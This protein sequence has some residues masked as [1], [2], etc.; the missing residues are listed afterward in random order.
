ATGQVRR[1]IAARGLP[2]GT[3]EEGD[4]GRWFWQ[5][6]DGAR[7]EKLEDIERLFLL[8]PSQRFVLIGDDSQ[9]DPE[10][11]ATLLE[12]HPGARLEP[13]PDPDWEQTWIEARDHFVQTWRAHGHAAADALLA[14]FPR[15]RTFPKKRDE[16]DVLVS[17]PLVDADDLTVLDPTSKLLPTPC[18]RTFSGRMVSQRFNGPLPTSPVWDSADR[19]CDA[20]YGRSLLF[21]HSCIEQIVHVLQ[22]RKSRTGTL[23]YGDLLV[24]LDAA[25]SGE[26]AEALRAQVRQCYQVA[27]IDE[28]Q[29][30]DPVQ[31]RIF[32]QLFD[33]ADLRLFL[34]GDP[35][36]AI[37][38]FR[39]ADVQTYL[40]AREKATAG[41]FTLERNYRSDRRLVM[42]LN[43]LF[44][45][46]GRL[47]DTVFGDPPGD[48]QGIRYVP[49]DTPPEHH[50]DRLTGGEP[51]L[52]IV[53]FPGSLNDSSK[54]AGRSTMPLGKTWALQNL[55]RHLAGEMTALLRSGATIRRAP[56]DEPRAVRP[57]DL[58]VIVRS[59]DQARRVQS[60]LQQAG[61]PAVI[62]SGGD[63]LDTP[64]AATLQGLL[65]ALAHPTDASLVRTALITPVFGITGSGLDT[66]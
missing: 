45:Q 16:V 25:L 14:A 35:K 34:I 38:A 36:Q 1:R 64:E 5:G 60:A 2:A 20:A 15:N 41:T 3:L 63:V 66:L 33:G 30:T 52:R 29:D 42:G 23:T 47:G 27:L 51:P 40:A 37:Y 61:I 56:G 21:V 24:Q 59:N 31:W 22:Q 10:V 49:V 48:P 28:F 8:H 55:P 43:H 57:D 32:E 19:L 39:G 17:G 44:D 62:S 9:R 53:F 13:P 54:R 58:A 65:D 18:I 46:Q 4:L 11:Y 12:R 6:L 50:A 26:R 7:D